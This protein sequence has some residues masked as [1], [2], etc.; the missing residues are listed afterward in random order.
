MGLTMRQ[1]TSQRGVAEDHGWIELS[2]WRVSKEEGGGK[3][4]LKQASS[5]LCPEVAGRYFAL[6]AGCV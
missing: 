1:E 3:G 6:D 2:G 4:S 5:L